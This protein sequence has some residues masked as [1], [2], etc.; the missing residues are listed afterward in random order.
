MAFGFAQAFR[1]FGKLT[2]AGTIGASL[3]A[4][5]VG[6][7]QKTPSPGS[8]KGQFGA[9]SL[10]TQGPAQPIGFYAKGCMTGAVALPADGP[11]WEAM[12]LSRNRR[13]CRVR[14]GPDVD[15]AVTS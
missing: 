15:A 13:Q 2:L 1:T 10:P 11:T 14:S 3:A 7:Q 6:A 9:V 8:A 4:G 12:R 5:D